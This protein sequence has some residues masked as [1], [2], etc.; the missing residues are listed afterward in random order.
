MQCDM[1]KQISNFYAHKIQKQEHSTTTYLCLGQAPT[2]LLMGAMIKKSFN[3]FL[4][5]DGNMDH[6]QN[7]IIC[8]CIFHQNLSTTFQVF[9]GKETKAGRQKCNLLGVVIIDPLVCP[10]YCV[11]C[12]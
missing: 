10:E 11:W 3:K 4:D 2:I 8:S 6:R 5:P 12:L 1:T 9:F 7:R